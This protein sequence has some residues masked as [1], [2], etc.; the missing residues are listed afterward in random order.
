MS[1]SKTFMFAVMILMSSCNSQ[2]SGLKSSNFQEEF[3]SLKKTNKTLVLKNDSLLKVLNSIKKEYGPDKQVTDESE[4]LL[5]AY[6]LQLTRDKTGYIASEYENLFLPAITLEFKNLTQNDISENITL[7]VYFINEIT[8]EQISK[9][10][11]FF[12]DE[13]SKLMGGLTKQVTLKSSIG[14]SAVKN[15]KV[16][17]RLYLNDQFIRVF[18]IPPTEYL[19]RF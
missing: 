17:A 3:D 8:G 18:Q 16:S 14:W 9:D 12:L 19:G 10:Y 11:S 7:D 1:S 13:H 2:N 4:K 6:K 5:L 15:Q